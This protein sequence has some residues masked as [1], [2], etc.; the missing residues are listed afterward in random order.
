M[1]YNHKWHIPLKPLKAQLRTAVVQKIPAFAL[2]TVKALRVGLMLEISM[3]PI[4][5]FIETNST[6]LIKL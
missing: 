6:M 3:V 2:R 1:A 4:S 5:N